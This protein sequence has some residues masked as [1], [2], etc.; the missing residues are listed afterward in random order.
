[1]A[2]VIVGLVGPELLKGMGVVGQQ[3]DYSF[4]NLVGWFNRKVLPP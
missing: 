4:I 2:S 1:M 3:L